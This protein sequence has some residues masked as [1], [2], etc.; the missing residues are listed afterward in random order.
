MKR[1]AV[2]GTVRG[3]VAPTRQRRTLR[4][5]QV[6]LVLVAGGLLVFGGYAL[7]KSAGYED[8]Q[9][10]ALGAA[11]AL[12]GPAGPRMPTPGRLE[13]LAGRAEDEAIGRAERVA[14]E[15]ES[16]SSHREKRSS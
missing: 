16:A 7:G 4:M 5:V 13:E 12:Q 3:P 9:K 11:V 2:A 8:A 10:G 1:Q 14:A 6:L 15:K